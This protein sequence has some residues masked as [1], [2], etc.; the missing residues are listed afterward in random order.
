MNT[1]RDMAWHHRCH[2][3]HFAIIAWLMCVCIR[4]VCRGEN[5]STRASLLT[6][7]TPFPHA[8]RTSVVHASSFAATPPS[9][10]SL[11]PSPSPNSGLKLFSW[12]LCERG[13]LA[14]RSHKNNSNNNNHNND[15]NRWHSARLLQPS[16]MHTHTLTSHIAH[17]RSGT[18]GN[19][20][21]D[22]SSCQTTNNP[23]ANKN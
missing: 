8:I 1:R 23:N 19:C 21:V 7:H 13:T 22:I 2:D 10:R 11:S 16:S 4:F 17:R 20:V 5:F 6:L 9:P 18:K 12:I 15:N 3:S 14:V